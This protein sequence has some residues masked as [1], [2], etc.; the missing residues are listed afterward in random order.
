MNKPYIV[1][2]EKT[3]KQGGRQKFVLIKTLKG[4]IFASLPLEQAPQ[5]Y[6]IVDKVK[7]DKNLDNVEVLGGG[8]IGIYGN[9]INL[10]TSSF[11]YKY[12]PIQL[13]WSD[14]KI[15]LQKM[16]GDNYIVKL[17]EEE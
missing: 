12:G 14:L 9:I 11:S 10:E 7:K 4:F 6:N 2:N 13:T 16:I 3:K 17:S 5:H 8:Y 15:I 1:I